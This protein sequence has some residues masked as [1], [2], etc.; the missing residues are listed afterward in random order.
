MGHNTRDLFFATSSEVCL[1][2][3]SPCW[4]SGPS[5]TCPPIQRRGSSVLQIS[6]PGGVPVWRGFSSR[7]KQTSSPTPLFLPHPSLTLTNNHL[8]ASLGAAEER[9]GR[10]Q[11]L[12]MFAGIPLRFWSLCLPVTRASK[13]ERLREC[14]PL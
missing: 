8:G 11:L 9:G 10:G 7:E 13:R 14:R 6:N 12:Q 4:K 3:A 5:E 2:T 1:Q